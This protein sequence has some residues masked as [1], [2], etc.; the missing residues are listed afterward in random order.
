[1][2]PIKET[3]RR[4]E[5][6]TVFGH[7]PDGLSCCLKFCILLLY[8]IPVALAYTELQRDIEIS[9]FSWRLRWYERS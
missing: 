8:S 4:L 9:Q 3:T 6:T 1:M 2:R 7:A 5:T